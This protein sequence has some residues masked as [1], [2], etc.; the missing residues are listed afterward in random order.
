MSSERSITSASMQRTRP[1]ALGAQPAEDLFVLGVHAEL[2]PPARVGQRVVGRPR[3]LAGCVEAR[4]RE[5]QPEAAALGVDDLGLEARQD[6]QRLRVALEP[7]EALGPL[8][9]RP[10]AVVAE[11]RMPEVVAEAGGVDDVGGEVAARSRARA[12]PVRPRASGSGGCVR[13]RPGSP[14]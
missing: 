14:G 2:Q 6:A 12:R 5:V 1:G 13:S 7:A 11:G 8:V 3:V 10:L 4:A 9:Q